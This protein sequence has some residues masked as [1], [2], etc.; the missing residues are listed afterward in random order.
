MDCSVSVARILSFLLYWI[1]TLVSRPFSVFFCKE[2]LGQCVTHSQFS[3]VKDCFVSV[4]C[5]LNF[6]LYW[7]V[8]LVSRAFSVFSCNGLLRLVSRAFS[9]F[10]CNGL[11]RQC[12]LVHSQFSLVMGCYVSAVSCILNF[13]LLWIVTSVPSRAFSIFSCYG[14]FCQCLPHSQFSFE[15]G[16]VSVSRILSSF[17]VMDCYVSVSR[18]LS[19]FL[20]WIVPLVCHAFSIFS[21][22]GSFSQCLTHSQ[23]FFCYGLLRQ[24]V[25]HSQFSRVT[26]CYVS[27]LCILSFLL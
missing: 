10:S 14:L 3:P 7:I 20:L 1:V 9:I 11:L 27:V 4:S 13:L 16:S 15:M 25:A 26:D 18:I 21:C 24:Y 17:F 5:I 19:V 6:L 23:F 22:N 2:L 8:P 12:R